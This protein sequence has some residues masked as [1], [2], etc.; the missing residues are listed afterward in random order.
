MSSLAPNGP[1]GQTSNDMLTP[2]LKIGDNSVLFHPALERPSTVDMNAEG[3]THFPSLKDV[4][5]IGNARQNIHD[6]SSN[7]LLPIKPLYWGPSPTYIMDTGAGID[8]VG[9]ADCSDHDLKRA[10][11]MDCP[12]T[13]W[14]AAGPTEA[15][16]TIH[17]DLDSLGEGIDAVV[18]DNTPALLS[19]GLRVETKGYG[20]FWEPWKNRAVLLRPGRPYKLVYLSLIHI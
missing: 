20:F 2:I 3:V 4:A 19:V 13:F 15:A 10:E 14:T 12:I 9:R 18:M 6:H 8:A 17:Y 1:G 7:T 11:P 5:I 16:T